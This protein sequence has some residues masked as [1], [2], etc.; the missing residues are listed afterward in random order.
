VTALARGG[1]TAAARTVIEGIVQRLSQRSPDLLP[2]LP[3]AQRQ[4]YRSLFE[5]RGVSNWE[6]RLTDGDQPPTLAGEEVTVPFAVIVNF[7]QQNARAE[8]PIR[9]RAHLEQ[10]GNSWR[11]RALDILP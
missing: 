10:V 6:A 1:V 11:A 5:S 7:T 3:A 4:T 2:M 8:L 9:F